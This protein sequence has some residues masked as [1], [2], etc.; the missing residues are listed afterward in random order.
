MHPGG[1][2]MYRDLRDLYW[3]TGLK[4]EKLANLYI[5]EIVRLH[6]VSLSRCVIDFRGS[7]K[8]YFS[9][10]EFAN[11]NNFQSSIQMAPYEAL[12]GR[13]CRT[14]L[15]WIELGERRVLGPELVFEIEDKVRLIRDRLKVASDR[16]KLY[17]N[18]KTC[19]IE[20]SMG[21]FFLL[22]VSP[23]KK[24]VASREDRDST[25]TGS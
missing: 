6:G 15:C 5:S 14:P 21:D 2:K 11:N 23:W 25:L 1:N 16:Q 17:A 9:L 7:W 8:D 24:A 4:H 22:K 18:L 13:K 12:Y 19:D 10:A 20:Y 3:W